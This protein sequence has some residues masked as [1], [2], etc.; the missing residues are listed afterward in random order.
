[1]SYES[2]ILMDSYNRMALEKIPSVIGNDSTPGS[3][4]MA[5]PDDRGIPRF[6]IQRNRGI[7]QEGVNDRG[8]TLTAR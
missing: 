5:F 4:A 3:G 2:D 6:L 1:M 7:L 8:G